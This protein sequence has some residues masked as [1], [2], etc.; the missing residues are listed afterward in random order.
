MGILESLK[1]GFV[2]GDGGYLEEAKFR[3]YSTPKVIVEFPEV[4]RQ[5]HVDFFRAGSQ[6]LQA[7]TWWTTRKYLKQRGGDR[8]W[9]DR[10][11]EI[12]RTAVQLAKEAAA[13]WSAARKDPRWRCC[14]TWRKAGP[15]STCNTVSVEPPLRP[16]QWKIHAVRCGGLSAT[17]IDTDLIPP[18]LCCPG[19]RPAAILH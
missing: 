18:V 4:L 12:N 14:R 7:H 17:R 13:G 9:A 2:L 6:V 8:G 1:K 19:A 10:M 3:G 11:E 5:I 15:R 16:P